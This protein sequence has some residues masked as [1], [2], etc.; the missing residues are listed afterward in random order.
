MSADVE[1]TNVSHSRFINEASPRTRWKDDIDNEGALKGIE[2]AEEHFADLKPGKGKL[3]PTSTHLFKLILPLGHLSSRYNSKNEESSPAPPTVFLLHPSQPLSHVSRLILASLA[4]ATPSITFRSTS[5]TTGSEF[6]WSDATDVAD[7]ARDAASAREFW[8]HISNSP[9]P[10][11]GVSP[12]LKDPK[13]ESNQVD[14]LQDTVIEVEVPTF[15]DRTRYLRRRLDIIGRELKEMET[16][17]KKCDSEAHRSA[18]SL[19]VGGL[20]ML[21]V[22]WGVVARLT[23]WDLGW[24]VMEPVTYLSGLSMVILGYL[25]FLYQGREV[26]YASVLDRSISAHR[27]ALYRAHG[28]DIDRWIELVNEAKQVKREI[29]KIAADYDEHKREAEPRKEN[30][31]PSASASTG[32]GKGNAE[33]AGLHMQDRDGDGVLEGAEILSDQEVKKEDKKRKIQLDREGRD[34]SSADEVING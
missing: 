12:Q 33:K 9:I 31:T 22:Y 19:A 6:Q 25:W 4:P 32:E 20:A 16:L 8:I 15:A 27:E 11:V 30:D 34:V 2:E 26:S 7:F 23:F 1:N 28:F 21:V 5:P 17:K 13:G 10:A 18:R 29:A 24:D 14:G 3:S